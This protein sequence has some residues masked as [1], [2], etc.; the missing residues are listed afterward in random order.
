MR[1]PVSP[2]SPVSPVLC[3]NQRAVWRP[4]SGAGIVRVR[5][6][7]PASWQPVLPFLDGRGGFSLGGPAALVLLPSQG[8]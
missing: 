5:R 4:G 3:A 7:S 2:V 1:F 6:N 8:L